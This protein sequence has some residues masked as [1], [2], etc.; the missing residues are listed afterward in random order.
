MLLIAAFISLLIMPYEGIGLGGLYIA[1]RFSTFVKYI[2]L[3]SSI[4]IFVEMFRYIHLKPFSHFE[5]PVIILMAILGM[6]CMTSANDM[7][8]FYMALE[9]Q[10]LALYVLI[11]MNRKNV[12]SIEAALK[13]FVLGV[14]SS[15]FLL[16]GISFIYGFTGCTNFSQ[17]ATFFF[18]GQQY[19]VLIVGVVLILVGL[20][21]K[22]ALV[23]FH[24]WIPDV[25]Q[26][27]P[28]FVT[29]FLATVPKFVVTMALC[30]ITSVF[31]PI[32]SDVL[33]IFMFVS[34]VSMVLGSVVAIQQHNLKRL[35][36][37]SAIGH[38]G[39]A[40]IGFS[41]GTFGIIAMIRYM[42]IYLIMT[43]G[44]FACI[45]SL[46]CKDRKNIKNISDL[47][48]LSRQDVFLTSALTIFLFSLAGIPPFAGFFGK[49]FL[50]IAAVKK[51]FYALTIIA[52]LS[53]VISA[54]YY[55]RMISILWFDPTT[56]GIII[57]AR[58]LKWVISACALFVV[59]YFLIENIL[60]SWI[61]RM[62]VSLF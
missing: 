10:S 4:V 24:M 36:A 26:G 34:I 3:L 16:Y 52:L 11:A 12:L 42:V 53:S 15:T 25:Y 13:Y 48:G 14:F 6:L 35:M 1:D 28:M 56:S 22:M 40:L 8:S 46:R 38:A 59:G 58:E 54:Y 61:T 37:Y 47:A 17:I 62:V 19:F 5:F 2:I 7:I 43:I 51:E 29:S 33:H 20:F 18:A 23:P 45:L 41:T 30:R 50:L 57:V 60:Y 27:S 9:L 44:F 21:F 39:Y 31:W 49:Y 32:L 55:L